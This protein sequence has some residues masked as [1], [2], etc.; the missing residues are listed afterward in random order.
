MFSLFV[1][2][3]YTYCQ[4]AAGVL[5]CENKELSAILKYKFKFTLGW[6]RLAVSLGN[7]ITDYVYRN[8]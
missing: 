1:G 6:L 8:N 7:K 4:Q 2:Y 3:T 5:S